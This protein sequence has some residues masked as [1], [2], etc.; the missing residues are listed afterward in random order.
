ML[1]QHSGQ[2]HVAEAG[3]R[4]LKL[5]G[6]AAASRNTREL[7][8]IRSRLKEQPRP[9]LLPQAMGTDM[10]LLTKGSRSM[11][12]YR[13]DAP[14]DNAP[15]PPVPPGADF[16]GAGDATTADLAWAMATGEDHLKCAMASVA[17]LLRHSADSYALQDAPATHP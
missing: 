3:P 5:K 9:E 15:A 1:P 13:Q 2:R 14:A 6:Q 4:L 11:T 7:G 10:V 16:V 17:A 12:L 8:A